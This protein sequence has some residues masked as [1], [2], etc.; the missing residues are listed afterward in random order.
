V[1]P[2]KAEGPASTAIDDRAKE[3]PVCLPRHFDNAESPNRQAPYRPQKAQLA[4]RGDDLYE[5]PPEAVR[6]LLKAERLPQR[7]W[8]CACGP[9]AI[10]RVLRAAGHKVHATDLVDYGCPDSEAGVDFLMESRAPDGVEAII[11]NPHYKLAAQFVEHAIELC[12]KVYL[13]LPLAF[14]EGRRRSTVLESGALARIHVFRNRLPRMH[15]HGWNGPRATS[16]VAFAWFVW[17]RSHRG[18]TEVRRLSWEVQ[19]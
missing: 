14:L 3:C 12:P 7:I 19:S 5:S 6:A 11:T 8:E 2:Q 17:D 15:R 9:G 18:P 1:Q 4:E 13:L 10:V 16:T